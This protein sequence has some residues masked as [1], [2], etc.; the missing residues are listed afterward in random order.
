MRFEFATA[1]R[2][3]F[4]RGALKEVGSLAKPLG[5]RA[6]VVTGRDP[7]RT[8]RLP[9][10]LDQHGVKSVCFS[11]SGEPSVETVE[12]GAALSKQHN[13]N[14][15]IGFGGGSALDAGKAISAMATNPGELL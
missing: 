9:A 8:E 5:K 1:S 15:I 6:L 13:C 11:V 14:L 12:K 10:A 3:V 2:I 7:R 4:G